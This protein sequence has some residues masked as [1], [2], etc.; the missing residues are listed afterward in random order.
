[1]QISFAGL[2]TEV[3]DTWRDEST[4][5]YS[6]PA[7]SALQAR[8]SLNTQ[9]PLPQANIAIS[10]EDAGDLEAA[11][12]LDDR[13]EQLPRM[14]QGFELHGRGDAGGPGNPIV[15]AEYNVPAKV[16]LMQMLL[17]RRIGPLM[18]TLTGTA[19]QKSYDK[20]KQ[21]F[22]AAARALAAV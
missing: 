16:P 12:Y 13:L 9:R 18:V 19:L 1:M 8:L 20:V 7:D 2:K 10:W 6:M 14:I 15:Y 3:P 5:I 11:R 17:V 21:H 22:M 4:I